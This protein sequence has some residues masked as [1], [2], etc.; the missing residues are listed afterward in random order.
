MKGKIFG[1]LAGLLVSASC[2][3]TS[4]LGEGEVLYTGVKD[5]DVN[6]PDT[7]RLLEGVEDNIDIL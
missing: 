3:T 5:L 6:V 7:V 4:R 2:S 1:L